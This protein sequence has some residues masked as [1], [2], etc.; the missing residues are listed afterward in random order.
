MVAV[1]KQIGGKHAEISHELLTFLFI[2]KDGALGNV[3]QQ[4][5]DTFPK[6]F[7]GGVIEGILVCFLRTVTE[8]SLQL[9]EIVIDIFF[10]EFQP[11]GRLFGSSHS[12]IE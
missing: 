4:V 10:L 1:G 5:V 9:V 8:I 6:Q 3:S 2:G 12:L 11:Q 7:Y